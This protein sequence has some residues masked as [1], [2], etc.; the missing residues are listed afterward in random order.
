LLFIYSL[1][2]HGVTSLVEALCYK[3]EGNGFE[4]R[5]NNWIF[6]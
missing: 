6:K 3:L 5:W 2:G 1:W 4:S